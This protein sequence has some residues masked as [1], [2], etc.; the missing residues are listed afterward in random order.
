MG[1]GFGGGGVGVGFKIIET[2]GVTKFPKGERIT[3]KK[4]ITPKPSEVGRAGRM[5]QIGGKAE[6]EAERK[7]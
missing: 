1:R 3:E 2:R 7:K 6:E 4:T 5:I